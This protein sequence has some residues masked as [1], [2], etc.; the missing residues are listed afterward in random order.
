MFLVRHS[1]GVAPLPFSLEKCL[2]I[3][4]TIWF[5]TGDAKQIMCAQWTL[6]GFV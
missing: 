3:V 2:Y 1:Q 6:D 5:H 4:F